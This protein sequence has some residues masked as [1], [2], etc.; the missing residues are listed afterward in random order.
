MKKYSMKYSMLVLVW[1][2]PSIAAAQGKVGVGFF[3]PELMLPSQTHGFSYVNKLAAKLSATL[4]R[5]VQ[6]QAYRRSS[7]LER[8]VRAGRIQLAVLG[9]AYVAGT[10]RSGKVLAIAKTT[11][12]IRWSILTKGARL[13]NLKG[14][15]LQ[16]AAMGR[17]S[18]SA[19]RYALFGGQVDPKK[20]FKIRRSPSVDSA[21][22]AVR[23]GQADATFAPVDAGGGLSA[24]L[25]AIRLPPPAVVAVGKLPAADIAKAKQTILGFNES[26]SRH[27]RGFS[28]A[29]GGH[30][31][32]VAACRPKRLKMAL[33]PVRYRQ[34][35]LGDVVNVKQLQ[36]SLAPLGNLFW[37][38]NATGA[39]K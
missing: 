31:A 39:A 2:A 29:G 6:G 16:L 20:Y 21:I 37:V 1:V 10:G 19:V 12:P 30:G 22:Q 3:A 38:P 34:L 24:V 36:R 17:L 25:G 5:K 7:D 26:L 32:F 18:T 28:A 23:L 4:G 15:T 13:K 9:G 14:K 33:F 8:D 11:K 27:Y 35:P